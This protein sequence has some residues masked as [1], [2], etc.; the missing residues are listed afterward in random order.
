[1]SHNRSIHLWTFLIT[2]GIL[3]SDQVTK[4]LVSAFLSPYKSIEVIPGL[5]NFVYVKNRGGA[6]G[7][8]S[9]LPPLIRGLIF[10]SFALM[11]LCVL[12]F[13]YIRTKN[14]I[15]TRVGIAFLIGGALGNLFDR[16][17]WGMV[18]DFLDFYIKRYHWPAFN[19]ADTAI[20]IGL[21]LFL[22]DMLVQPSHGEC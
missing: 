20:C 18:V 11:A 4:Y 1:M 2:C 22:W 3:I 10:I 12:I 6:F 9:D 14:G 19:I 15:L 21:G 7:L 13:V 8:W 17:R 16:I 5:F